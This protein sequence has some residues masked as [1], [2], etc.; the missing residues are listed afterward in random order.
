MKRLSTKNYEHN[1]KIPLPAE[2]INGQSLG[3]VS[4]MKF[5]RSTM[6]YSGCEVISVY[7]ALLLEHRPQPFCEIARYM[8]R[9]RV[10]LGFWGTN[11][12]LLG[13]CLRHFGL[14]AKRVRSKEKLREAILRGQTCLF[15]YWV[16]KRFRSPVHTVCIRQSS[17]EWL[18]VYNAYNNCD[19]VIDVPRAEWLSRRMIFAYLIEPAQYLC[20]D[21]DGNLFLSFDKTEES[22]LSAQP[23]LT[24]CLAVVKSGDDWLLGWNRWR[25]RYEIF[26]GCIEAGETARDCIL[27]EC[28]EELGVTS[29]EIRYLGAMR[30]LMQPD[31]FS[32][33]ERTELGGLYGI[34]LPEMPSDALSEMCEDKD[35]ITHFALYSAIRG[36]A[37][38][39]E[40]D[41]YLLGYFK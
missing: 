2:P 13:H 1:Q 4:G 25:N 12:L 26:G 22:A 40:I 34:V 39:A 14:R 17:E 30:F 41:E 28:R 16:G 10:M 9:F 31:Y 6:S 38:I 7:N 35:E 8:E 15:V 36:K 19:H 23:E 3:A 37:P 18:A 11:F 20:K 32:S 33:E 5:G 29:F 27:R 21:S 24:H